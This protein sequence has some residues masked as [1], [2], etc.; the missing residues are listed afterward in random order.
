MADFHTAFGTTA[1]TTQPLCQEVLQ[2]KAS[3]H[4]AFGTTGNNN[5]TTVSGSITTKPSHPAFGTTATTTQPLCQEVLRRMA[6]FTRH[7][8]QRRQR[9]HDYCVRKYCDEW[10]LVTRHLERRQRQHNH[11]VRKYYN[12]RRVFTRHFERR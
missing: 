3:L 4:T 1:M 7:L 8:E 11:C 2:R 5:T 9:Q 10:P 12:R 6:I